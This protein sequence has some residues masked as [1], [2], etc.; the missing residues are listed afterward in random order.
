[1]TPSQPLEAIHRDGAAGPILALWPIEK[2]GPLAIIPRTARFGA[3]PE[4]KIATSTASPRPLI[5]VTTSEVR[6]GRPAGE[7]PHADP[8]Q[9]EMVL[10]MRYLRAVE[11]AGAIPVVVPPLADPGSLEALLSHVSGLCVSGG[12]DLDPAAY[13]ERRHAKLGPTWAELD[14][15]ELELV[16]G[17]DQRGLPI[18]A[19]CRGVQVLNVARG[20]SLHQHLPDVVGEDIAHRQPQP[21]RTTT[22]EVLLAPS[23]RMAAIVG[24]RRVAVNSFHHQAVA[25]V[26]AGLTVTGRAPDGVIESLEADDREFVLGVQW[27]A[28][29][30]IAEPG[31]AAL[32]GA[33][34]DAARRYAAAPRPLRLAA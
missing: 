13:R 26:G 14:E 15:F 22:H 3:A 29:G 11:A 33:L 21:A 1:M 6:P 23:S 12:P 9:D 17:A 30:L 34:T 19:I 8:P 31:H 28:E 2:S 7:N 5:A 18:L 25:R 24:E 27:H 10:G 20:G 32:F 16:R 4:D